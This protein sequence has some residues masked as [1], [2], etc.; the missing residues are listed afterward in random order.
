MDSVKVVAVASGAEIT[1]TLGDASS[2]L[3]MMRHVRGTLIKASVINRVYLDGAS[4]KAVV[5]LPNG[6]ATEAAAFLTSTFK[7]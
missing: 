2:A 7:G 3:L 4:V 1:W 6:A 5:A